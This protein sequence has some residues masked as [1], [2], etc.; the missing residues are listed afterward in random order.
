MIAVIDVFYD[1]EAQVIVPHSR[2]R[3]SVVYWKL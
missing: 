3:C 2:T 1:C